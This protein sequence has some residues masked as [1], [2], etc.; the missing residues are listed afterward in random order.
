MQEEEQEPDEGWQTAPTP[1]DYPHTHP[2]RNEEQE[3]AEDRW[4]RVV[5]HLTGRVR[6]VLKQEQY[7]LY[8]GNQ[9][10]RVQGTAGKHEPW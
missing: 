9:F 2:A 10:V 3:A 5:D 4:M 7:T 1:H 8:R 6:Y